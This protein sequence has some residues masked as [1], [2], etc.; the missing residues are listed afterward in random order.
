MEQTTPRSGLHLGAL[1]SFLLGVA[2]FALCLL[3][4]AWLPALL[5]GYRSLRTVNAS[6]G[7]RSGAWLAV[8]GMVLGGLATRIGPILG[9]IL[10]WFIFAGAQSTLAEMAKE[11]LLPGFLRGDDSQGALALALVGLGLMLLLIF[12]PQGIVGS[13]EEMSLD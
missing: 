9:A 5:I 13:R 4:V 2:S 10:F 12:R 11:D 7:K 8:G 1:L 6:G 3:A